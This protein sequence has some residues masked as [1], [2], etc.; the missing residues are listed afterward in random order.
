MPAPVTPS[1]SSPIVVCRPALPCDKAD[2]LE[3]TKFIWDGHDYIQYVW[4]E[5]LAAPHGLL[6]AAEY[7][8]RTVGLAKLSLSAPGQWWLQGLRVDPQFQG[9]K[10]GSHIHRY[11]DAWWLEHGDGVARLMTSSK[12]VK[13]HHLCEKF[14][15]AK[16]LE[17]KEFETDSLDEECASFQPVQK[18][19]VPAALKAAL[20]SQTLA[21]SHGLLD[22]GW[23]ALQ[24]TEMIL[25]TVQQ[26]GMAFWWRDGEGLLLGWDDDYG[27]EKILGISLPACTLDSLPD[28]LRD[29]RR[30]AAGQGRAGVFWIAP[31]CPE[32]LSAAEA[33]GY[34]RHVE[35]SGYLYEKRHPARENMS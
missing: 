9:L 26:Q 18:D 3:F 8:G 23:K 1:F 14:G 10:I 12:R 31:L 21:L 20:E 33:A 35:H 29:A 22:L 7:G 6:A 15:Y 2:V 27:E 30:L 25:A 34:R 17:V 13:V 19:E 5:W 4:D 24:F 32:T 28:L 11:V 16:V